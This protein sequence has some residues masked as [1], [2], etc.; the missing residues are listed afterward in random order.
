MAPD[1]T[2]RQGVRDTKD[3]TRGTLVFAAGP[4]QQFVTAVRDGEIA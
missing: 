2:G 4:W 3:R 1:G